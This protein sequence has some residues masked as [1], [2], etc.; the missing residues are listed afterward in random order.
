MYPWRHAR[1]GPLETLFDRRSKLS[2]LFDRFNVNYQ[3]ELA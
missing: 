2:L 3:S 1:F